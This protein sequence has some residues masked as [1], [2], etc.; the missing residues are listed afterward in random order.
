[1]ENRNINSKYCNIKSN[2][3][4]TKKEKNKKTKKY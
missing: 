4:I 2:R 1:M 3:K